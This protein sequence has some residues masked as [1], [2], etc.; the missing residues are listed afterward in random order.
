MPSSPYASHDGFG[1]TEGMAYRSR[2]LVFHVEHF[3]VQ[4]LLP[5]RYSHLLISLIAFLS[6]EVLKIQIEV[7][8]TPAVPYM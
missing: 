2:A 4:G 7:L 6:S 8:P 3:P 1:M 5:G